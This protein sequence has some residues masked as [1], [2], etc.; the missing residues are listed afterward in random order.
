MKVSNSAKAKEEKMGEDLEEKGVP[1]ERVGE[2][3]L[4]EKEN[5]NTRES[6]TDLEN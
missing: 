4:V 5:K 1:Q 3:P 2:Q 6:I